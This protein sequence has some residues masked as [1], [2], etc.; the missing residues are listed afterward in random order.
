MVMIVMVKG[1]KWDM[2]TLRGY[3]LAGKIAMAMAQRLF[4]FLLGLVSIYLSISY[5]HDLHMNRSRVLLEIASCIESDP[6]SA[7]SRYHAQLIG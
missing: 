3:P 4:L 2:C 6:N 1:G 5:Q 7:H